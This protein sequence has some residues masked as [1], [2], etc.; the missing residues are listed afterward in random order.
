M[1][2]HRFFP[3][4][5]PEIFF[6]KFLVGP[7]HK[8]KMEFV[9]R[10]K[11]NHDFVNLVSS[12]QNKD[13]DHVRLGVSRFF[14]SVFK[15]ISDEA[16]KSAQENLASKARIIKERLDDFSRSLLLIVYDQQN[17]V[18]GLNLEG[19]KTGNLRERYGNKESGSK[20]KEIIGEYNES[21]HSLKEADLASFNVDEGN[22][23]V[24]REPERPIEF[25]VDFV[26][27]SFFIGDEGSK[28]INVLN[29]VIERMSSDE[30]IKAIEW[31]MAPGDRSIRD[32]L[33]Y[34]GRAL[35]GC[36]GSLSSVV[37]RTHNALPTQ[38]EDLDFVNHGDN[39]EKTYD[40]L[41]IPSHGAGNRNLPANYTN[42]RVPYPSEDIDNYSV[43]STSLNGKTGRNDPT[44]PSEKEEKM[45]EEKKIEDNNGRYI[46]KNIPT[47]PTNTTVSK[48]DP[49]EVKIEIDE[50]SQSNSPETVA[51][52]P[53]TISQKPAAEQAKVNSK[54]I[55]S[56]TLN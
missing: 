17:R 51:V 12:L 38:D 26:K 31:D 18:T 16:G 3:K 1:R 33:L 24:F 41:E 40:E 53:G 2:I 37:R 36:F 4:D 8:L 11:V 39:E 27:K 6:K 19:E 44:Y 52:S 48:V 13:E 43:N 10:D 15:S 30:D 28:R 29:D 9:M 25:L 20:K 5:Q 49:K 21:V 22:R 35:S 55:L 47:N 45:E 56:P 7:I 34:C 54:S 50:S 14:D 23:I 32:R 42:R 46:F